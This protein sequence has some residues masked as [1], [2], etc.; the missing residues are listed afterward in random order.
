MSS[1]AEIKKAFF[2]QPHFA[3]VGASKDENKWGTKVGI[4]HLYHPS[5]PPIL[6]IRF[7]QYG[8]KIES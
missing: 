2:S 8:A 5:L 1:K 6:L 4:L 7:N 3:V